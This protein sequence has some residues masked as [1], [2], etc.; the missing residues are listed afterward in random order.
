MPVADDK[1]PRFLCLEAQRGLLRDR[2]ARGAPRTA[3]WHNLAR[4][5]GQADIKG[6]ERP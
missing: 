1:P 2:D 6:N 3:T 4:L 5:P